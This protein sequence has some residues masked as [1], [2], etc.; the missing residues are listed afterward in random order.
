[1]KTTTERAIEAAMD[2]YQWDIAT[3][4]RNNAA[5][6]HIAGDLSAHR[7][8][9]IGISFNLVQKEALEYSKPYGELLYREGASIIQGEKIPWLK[10]RTGQTR[11]N[12][13]KTIRDDLKEGKPV[14]EIGGKRL[15][16]GTIAYDLK[17][18]MKAEDS[19]MV[20]IARTECY[21]SDTEVLTKDGWKYFNNIEKIDEIVTL[22][23]K[24][25]LEY[26][27]PSEIINYHYSGKMYHFKN[28][29]MLDLCVTPG[30]NLY[31]AD[32]LNQR[33][34][35]LSYTKYKLKKAEEC[36]GKRYRLKRDAIWHGIEQKEFV[37]PLSSGKGIENILSPISMDLW[38]EFL[39]YYISEGHSHIG[40]KNYEVNISQSPLIESWDNFEKIKICFSKLPFKSKFNNNH[41][42]R[43]YSKQLTEYLKDNYGSTAIKKHIPKEIKQLSS[44]QLNILLDALILGD[45]HISKGRKTEQRSYSTISKNLA[46][47]VLEILLKTNQS[48]NIGIVD[49]RGEKAPNGITRHIKYVIGIHTIQLHPYVNLSPPKQCKDEWINYEGEVGCVTVP[50]G[51]IY[52]RRNGKLLW[53]GNCA[54]IQSAGSM[55]RYKANNVKKIKILC[56]ADPCEICIPYCNRIMNFDDVPEIPLHPNCRCSYSPVIERK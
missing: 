27:Y 8:L 47:D 23:K 48:G 14:S 20:R 13:F 49:A 32:N 17:Q 5:R 24:G 53:C 28:T 35:R 25:E 41:S 3:A 30:H 16:K 33:D 56:A 44:R 31:I 54:R 7:L 11:E 26:Q 43:I 21:S 46:D 50:N 34:Q 22:N 52:V 1:M 55:T 10:D 51:I 18:I 19:G 42:F 38:L 45:G 9:D 15:G 39:G 37:L 6:A 40:K 4:A 2:E 36:F 29:K 12:V